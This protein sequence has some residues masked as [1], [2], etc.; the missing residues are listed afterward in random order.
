MYTSNDPMFEDSMKDFEAIE[1]DKNKNVDEQEEVEEDKIDEKEWIWT[2]RKLQNAINDI[3]IRLQRIDPASFKSKESYN[4]TKS[5]WEAQI[6]EYEAAM[7]SPETIEQFNQKEKE[8]RYA[9]VRKMATEESKSNEQEEV[10]E[11]K[12]IPVGFDINGVEIKKGDEVSTSDAHPIQG[13]VSTVWDNGCVDIEYT[14]GPGGPLADTFDIKGHGVQKLDVEE[15]TNEQEEEK[16]PP[17]AVSR[18]RGA[19]VVTACEIERYI[20]RAENSMGTPSELL[21]QRSQLLKKPLTKD[22]RELVTG[23]DKYLKEWIGDLSVRSGRDSPYETMWIISGLPDDILKMCE[24]ASIEMGKG[25]GIPSH[26]FEDMLSSLQEL[27]D[28][29]E[30][31]LD[32]S[33]ELSGENDVAFDIGY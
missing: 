8:K 26:E 6:E 16:I 33:V 4:D 7:E 12:E 17:G 3:K 27:Y 32:S 13:T 5:S 24:E 14:S 2:K 21:I 1:N 31:V 15:K 19:E 9:E 11:Q 30:D 23:G 22:Q 20:E 25:E 10:K 29:S 18:A 28:L